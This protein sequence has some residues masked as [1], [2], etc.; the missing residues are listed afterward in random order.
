ML[1]FNEENGGFESL[2]SLISL[3]VEAQRIPEFIMQQ[4][5]DDLN[6]PMFIRNLLLVCTA[7]LNTKSREEFILY[8]LI[9]LIK[10]D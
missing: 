6:D 2:V 4:Y 8:C 5:G 10:K 1:T 7:M 3:I 9:N